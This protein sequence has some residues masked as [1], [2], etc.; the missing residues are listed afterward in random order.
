[1]KLNLLLLSLLCLAS[2]SAFAHDHA[3]MLKMQ[4]EAA[5]AAPSSDSLHN[6]RAPLLDQQGKRFT[7]ADEHGPATLVTMFYGDCQIACPIVVENVKR[8]VEATP[9][10]QRPQLRALLISLNPGVNTPAKL[11]KLASLHQLPASTYRFAVSDNESHTRELAA[12]LGIKYRRVGKEI[13]HSTRFVVLD[14][15]GRVV[16]SSDKLSIEPDAAV[17]AAIQASTGATTT[18]AH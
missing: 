3:E 6:L 5:R 18:H 2:A 7:L 10:A 14:H 15:Q 4:A 17:L 16:A 12:A 8:T 13:N 9:A 1:M 11:A